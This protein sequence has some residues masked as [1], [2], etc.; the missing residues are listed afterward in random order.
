MR[1][2]NLLEPKTLIDR[3]AACPPEGFS[4]IGDAPAPAFLAPFD[5]L[6][7]A[8]AD[9]VARLS[10]WP[11]FRTWRRFLRLRTTF[12]GTTVT[13]YAPVPE[14]GAADAQ[15]AADLAAALRERLGR[16]AALTILKDLPQASPLLSP[17][18]NVFA[19][20]LARAC[21]ARD[22]IQ[23]AGQALAY[24][25]IDFNNV[26]DYIARLKRRDAKYIRKKLAAR[27]GLTVS[28]VRTG[29]ACF[30][31]T[32]VR[33][34]YAMYE[35]VYAQSEIHFDKL[36]YEFFAAVLTDPAQ[37]GVVFEYRNQDGAFIGWNLCFEH[38]GM[39]IDKY[40]GFVYPQAR[41]A[42][43]YFVSW[44]VN[45]DYALERGLNHYVAGWTDPEVKALLGAR[46]TFTRHLVFIRNPLLRALGR[47]MAGSF[48]SDRTWSDKAGNVMKESA[49]P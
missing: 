49:K 36:T 48:E 10:Q 12:I 21:E 9:F 25:P 37:N 26:D 35:Q 33:R 24:V 44:F 2:R 4:V 39:L 27:A 43:L 47:R 15:A 3:W 7:T 42:N 14:T 32:T 19:D 31:E 40:I 11:G 5:L 22:F 13:E 16:G 20:E 17:Q 8:D 46:F 30:D 18:D 1:W 34:Y 23:L 45:L 41:E 6:T 38:Q 29:D 28:V